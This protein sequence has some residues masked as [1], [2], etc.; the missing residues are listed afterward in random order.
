MNDT[1]LQRHWRVSRR[2]FEPLNR[3][4]RERDGLARRNAVPMHIRTMFLYYM[5]NQNCFREISDKF[6]VSISTAHDSI[7]KTLEQISDIAEDYIEWP[8]NHEKQTG[9]GVFKRIT[10]IDNVIGAIDGCH[11]KIQKPPGCRGEDSINRKSYSIS[12][13]AMW[14]WRET[15]KRFYWATWKSASCPH[16]KKKIRFFLWNGKLKWHNTSY[17]GTV[18]IYLDSFLSSKHHE[19]T[20]NTKFSNGRVIIENIYERMKCRWRRIR[21]LQNVNLVFMCRIVMAACVLHNFCMGELC[22]EHP[23]GCPREEHDHQWFMDTWV[24]QQKHIYCSSP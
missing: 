15:I 10:D 4:L 8:T 3:K 12:L 16:V 23:N 2:K 1:T 14:W 13:Q 17:S 6:N 18:L 20:K 11:I 5:A 24:T 22:E 7:M 21:E 19:E 9:A